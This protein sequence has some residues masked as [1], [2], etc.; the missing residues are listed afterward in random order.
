M[1]SSEALVSA[2]PVSSA[3][4][5]TSI[6]SILDFPQGLKPL[7]FSRYERHD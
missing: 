6:D 3:C 2:E 5:S 7:I 4:V 1:A